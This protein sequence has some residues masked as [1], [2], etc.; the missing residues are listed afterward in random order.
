[1]LRARGTLFRPKLTRELTK[2][3]GTWT[4]RSEIARGIDCNRSQGP[5]MDK[6]RVFDT[7]TCMEVALQVPIRGNGSRRILDALLA[8]AMLS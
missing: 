3:D 1:M 2:S 8:Y 6:M 7:P 5:E 4:I